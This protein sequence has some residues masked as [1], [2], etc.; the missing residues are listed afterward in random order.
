MN[1]TPDLWETLQQWAR[2]QIAEMQRRLTVGEPFGPMIT[3]VMPDGTCIVVP[4]MG[5]STSGMRVALL[6]AVAAVGC[7]AVMMAS[8]ANIRANTPE[9][10][11][12][13]EALFV[14]IEAKS[15]ERVQFHC[16]VH[17][18]RTGFGPVERSVDASWLEPI[19]DRP[20]H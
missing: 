11:I 20:V 19:W 15:G 14:Y 3:G 6:R 13:G 5:E 2:E 7:D 1:M 9:Q 4:I 17:A 12:L 16:A 18:G 8:I 10:P